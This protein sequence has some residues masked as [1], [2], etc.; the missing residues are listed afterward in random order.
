[1]S[2]G[3]TFTFEGATYAVALSARTT[4]EDLQRACASRLGLSPAA[5]RDVVAFTSGQVLYP[6]SYVVHFAP[7]GAFTNKVLQLVLRGR[8]ASEA[9]PKSQA[10]GMKFDIGGKSEVVVEMKDKDLKAFALVKERSR[11]GALDLQKLYSCFRR[12]AGGAERLT[13]VGFDGCIRELV[14]GQLLSRGEKQFLSF[15][16]SKIFHAFDRD[17]DDTVDFKEFIAGFSILALGGEREKLE[18]AFA[19]FDRDGDGFIDRQELTSYLR[20]F[21]TAVLALNSDIVRLNADYVNDLIERT[22]RRMCAKAFE[23]ADTNHDDRLSYEEMYAWYRNGGDILMPWLSLVASPA[24]IPPAVTEEDALGAE[25]AVELANGRRLD[26]H[27]GR[28]EEEELEEEEALMLFP[29]IGEA[30]LEIEAEDVGTL[31]AV[32][33]ATRLNQVD[34]QQ[35]IRAFVQVSGRLEELSSFMQ[36]ECE[37]V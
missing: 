17:G 7:S 6:P 10:A 27:G 30:Q 23:T 26:M 32:I 12:F 1:M 24:V 20:A 34:A 31:N 35:I 22:A 16:L 2:T 9:A 15:G 28:E 21:L 19:L 8:A 18:F 11:L 13:K 5:W 14:P 4:K 3:I 37:N 36:R 33:E 25:E 29:L